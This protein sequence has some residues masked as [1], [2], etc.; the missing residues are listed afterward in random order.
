MEDVLDYLGDG[1]LAQKS[2]AHATKNQR[3]ANYFVD[4]LA[5]YILVFISGIIIAGLFLTDFEEGTVQYADDSI[6]STVFQY[7]MAYFII[8]TYY[9]FSEYF[10]KG[11][12][13]GK[14]IT[15]TRAV[16]LD[17]QPLTLQ[18]AFLRSLCRIVPFEAFSFLGNT[19]QGWHD[20]WTDTKVIEDREWV[21]PSNYV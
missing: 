8:L 13:I 6:E 12:T 11:K 20:K 2:Y 15:R 4:M 18:K 7:F 17:N 16:T 14:Y 19:P 21:S 1:E 5:Y 3:L 9:T 10:L